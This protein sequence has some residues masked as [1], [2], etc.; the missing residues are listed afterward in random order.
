[1]VGNVDINQV[2]Q[3]N[4]LLKQYRDQ[5]AKVNAEIEF[6]SKELESLC[7]ELSTELGIT[8]TP[9]NLEQVYEER[10]AKINST[11]QSGTEILN[12]IKMETQMGF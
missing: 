9:D 5:A 6:N 8:V 4:D 2:R 10:V 3:Y 1:M 7:Q 12:R 11:L